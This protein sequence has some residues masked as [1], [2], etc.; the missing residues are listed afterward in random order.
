M[1]KIK[2]F[3]KT[4][5]KKEQTFGTHGQKQVAWSK[6][7]H[8]N[9]CA[10]RTFASGLCSPKSRECVDGFKKKTYSE[11]LKASLAFGNNKKFKSIKLKNNCVLSGKDGK[12][13]LSTIPENLKILSL[14][15]FEKNC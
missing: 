1:L 4:K 2:S 13:R 8:S 12:C 6:V 5:I 7:H 15:L 14:P 10:T 3:N 11:V 9:D